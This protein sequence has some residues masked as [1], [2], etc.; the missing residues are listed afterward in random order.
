MRKD[1]IKGIIKNVSENF[2]ICIEYYNSKRYDIAL[3]FYTANMKSLENI[4]YAANVENIDPDDYKNAKKVY[5]RGRAIY[6]M[7]KDTID[8]ENKSLTK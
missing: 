3:A 4:V 7:I 6:R 2:N 5:N 8:E 1:E